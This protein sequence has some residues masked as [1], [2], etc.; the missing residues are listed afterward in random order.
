MDTLTP[1]CRWTDAQLPKTSARL[2][3]AVFKTCCQT[4]ACEVAAE[5]MDNDSSL[6]A[7][8]HL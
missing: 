1:R 6:T 4:H 7:A 3:Q 8:E 2:I 5:S